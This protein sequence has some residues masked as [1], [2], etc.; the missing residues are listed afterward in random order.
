MGWN[1][2]HHAMH[3]I[4]YLWHALPRQISPWSVYVYTVVPAV[5]KI[6]EILRILPNLKFWNF[7]I[8]YPCIFGRRTKFGVQEWTHSCQISAWSVSTIANAGRKTIE[9]PWVWPNFKYRGYIITS[10]PVPT[11][12]SMPNLAWKSGPKEYSSMPNVT[13]NCLSRR[14]MREKNQIWPYF[15]LQHSAVASKLNADK[16]KPS[17]IQ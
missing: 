2:A 13:L 7:G 16:Y 11:H 12:R 5:R 9:F 1:L 17:P 10:M 8:P 3:C 4:V 14:P 6:S 15:Q